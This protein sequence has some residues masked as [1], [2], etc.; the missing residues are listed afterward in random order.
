MRGTE[1]ITEE[2]IAK[3]TDALKKVI[4]DFFPQ[5]SGWFIPPTSSTKDVAKLKLPNGVGTLSIIIQYLDED[6]ED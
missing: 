6:N 2:I 4:T 3:T 1:I 5:Q